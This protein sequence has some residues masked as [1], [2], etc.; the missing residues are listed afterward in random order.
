MQSLRLRFA[1]VAVATALLCALA[2]G[3]ATQGLFERHVERETLAELDADLRFLARSVVIDH[4]AASLQVDPLPDPR[5]QEPGS[6]LYWQIR[7]EHAGLALSSPSLAG[8]EIR[9]PEDGLQPGELHR[10]VM[11]GPAGSKMIVLERLIPGAVESA[12][13]YRVAAAIDR[14]IL[15]AANRSFIVDLLPVLGMVIVGLLASFALQGMVALHPIARARAVLVEIH[16]GRREGIGKALPSELSGLAR[17]FDSLLAAQRR[18]TIEARDRANDLA[19][20]LRTP[21]ALLNAR[22]RSLRERGQ[23]AAASDIED[24]TARIETRLG[25]E[26]ARTRIRGPRE[27]TRPIILADRA[28]RVLRALARTPQGED[29]A[30]TIDIPTHMSVK[31]DEGDLDELLGSLLENARGWSTS[32]VRLQARIEPLCPILVIEDDGPGIPPHQR[33]AAL[34]RGGRIAFDPTRRGTGLGLAIARDI[35]A[36]YGGEVVLAES[37]LGGLKV[38]VTLPK[39]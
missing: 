25:R 6:G 32:R 37:D 35:A 34:A 38:R 11:N 28:E 3:F 19:H 12:G 22:A 5:F 30:W 8:F 23:D 1:V 21:L 31:V 15:E 14:K 16:A 39:A 27:G 20:G 13:A 26:L 10:H 2:I 29:L 7:S 33:N 36:A 9:L 24:V 4:G 17:D 18:E